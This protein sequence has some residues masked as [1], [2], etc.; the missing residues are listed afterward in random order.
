VLRQQRHTLPPEV[1][2]QL[3]AQV[4]PASSSTVGAVT[5]AGEQEIATKKN[6]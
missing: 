6:E 5:G 2:W 4:R 1:F 3:A